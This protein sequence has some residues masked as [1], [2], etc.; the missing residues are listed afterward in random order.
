MKKSRMYAART[1]IDVV[2]RMRCADKD[3]QRELNTLRV[4]MSRQVKAG[5]PWRAEPSLD[6]ISMLDQPAWAGAGRAH[7]RVSRDS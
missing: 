2:R 1:L 7:R 3:I 4:A 5:T 6:V